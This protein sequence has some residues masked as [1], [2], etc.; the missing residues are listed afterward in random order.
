M[1]RI[2]LRVEFLALRESNSMSTTLL[3]TALDQ[4]RTGRGLFR[5]VFSVS[6]ALLL[7]CS[8]VPVRS[9]EVTAQSAAYNLSEG[10]KLL[11]QKEP[12]IAIEK[13][14]NPIIDYYQ[15]HYSNSGVTVY[16]AV[17]RGEAFTYSS[18]AV[19]GT[20]AGRTIVLDGT[21]AS[22]LIFKGIALTELGRTDAAVAVLK[23]ATELAPW[24]P[25]A[26]YQL[27][28]IEQ[29]RK[30]WAAALYA[31][32]EAAIGC[33]WAGL[34]PTQPLSQRIL[35]GE[36]Y[37]LTKLGDLANAEGFYKQYLM[38]NP[39]DDRAKKELAYVE[40]IKDRP[41]PITSAEASHNAWIVVA[42]QPGTVFE[43]PAL[44]PENLTHDQPAESGL[45]D[46]TGAA[47]RFKN[48]GDIALDAAGNLFVLDQNDT[49]VRK[50]TPVGI[51]TTLARLPKPK[52][53][54]FYD[55]HDRIAIAHDGGIFVSLV[56]ENIILRISTNG[57]EVVYAGQPNV[58]GNR[59]GPRARALFSAPQGLA[60]DQG[61]NLYVAD[62]ANNAIREIKSTGLV[63]TLTGGPPGLRDGP[64]ASARFEAPTSLAI[65]KSGNIYVAEYVSVEDEGQGNL[66]CAVRE[67]G[68]NGTVVTLGEDAYAHDRGN[69]VAPTHELGDWLMMDSESDAAIAVDSHEFLYFFTG[70]DGMGRVAL[71]HP[72]SEGTDEL[73]RVDRWP[74]LPMPVSIVGIAVDK[75]GTVFVSDAGLSTIFKASPPW[76]SRGS[77][78]PPL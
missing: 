9:A 32:K 55:G 54:A 3:V 22:A 60:F 70:L 64:L 77:S 23:R 74:K 6:L 36:A 53:N 56:N 31:Y 76:G 78:P 10:L 50:I 33:G 30:S 62:S 24:N 4:S 45:R 28:Y 71:S 63:T 18:G 65:D 69:R 26:W 51:V 5:N 40:Q 73:L 57:R 14:F 19:G 72:Y 2:A 68:V 12:E 29:S 39:Q 61:G 47:A 8:A 20:P 46:G 48:P 7:A 37:V 52:P 11:Q 35:Y 34:S 15:R 42:G 44:A 58:A 67:I 59:D 1:T 13:Y 41:A 66:A 17:T 16:S 27:G 21:W 49:V 25:A 38:L 43:N 75:R